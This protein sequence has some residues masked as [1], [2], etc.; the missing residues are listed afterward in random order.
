MADSTAIA[1]PLLCNTLHVTLLLVMAKSI[2]LPLA[3]YT[4]LTVQQCILGGCLQA[5]YSA[6][7]LACLDNDRLERAGE[8]YQVALEAGLHPDVH[9]YNG[10]INAYGRASEV[11]CSRYAYVCYSMCPRTGFWH[12]RQ[13]KH[14]LT[15]F[16]AAIAWQWSAM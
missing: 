5:T 2:L 14:N 12:A 16:A 11:G 15:M 8:L 4:G 10:L 3:F 6:L 7:I 1:A 9:A 13:Q